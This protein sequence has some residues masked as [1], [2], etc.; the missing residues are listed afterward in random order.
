MTAH[1]RKTG[2]TQKPCVHPGSGSTGLWSSD[3]EDTGLN[4]KSGRISSIREY[5]ADKGNT[6]DVKHPLNNDPSDDKKT[7]HAFLMSQY[8]K[9]KGIF[10][11]LVIAWGTGKGLMH[12]VHISIHILSWQNTIIWHHITILK[13]M[14]LTIFSQ[15]EMCLT[16]KITEIRSCGPHINAFGICIVLS[17]FSY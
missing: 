3:P 17:A 10:S 9:D 14:Y 13:E 6:S 16:P 5:T 4:R 8:E 11:H 2:S 15:C 1:G 7:L 12:G